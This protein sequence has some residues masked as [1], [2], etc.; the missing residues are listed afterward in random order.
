M[1]CK[2]LFALC[3]AALAGT[4]LAADWPGWRGPDR[5][6]VS[7]E[8]G[9]LKKWPKAGPALLWKFD[10]AG[11]GYS[12]M[13][14]VGDVLYSM[15]GE[16]G[17]EYLFAVDLKTRKKMWSAEVGPIFTEGHG[18]G[19]RGTPTIDGDL[20]FGIGGQGNLICVK[21]GSGE[22]VWLKS[23]KKDFA[24]EMMT[25]WGYTESPLVD[26]DLVIGTP[27]GRQG[28]LVAFKKATGELV[29]QTKDFTDR[30]AYCSAVA[31]DIGG[32]HQVIQ[33]T[34]N[35]VVGVDAKT[36]DVLW[37]QQRAGKTAVIPTPVVKD[38]L[39]YVTSG[40]G[41]GCNLIR[42][43]AANGTFKAEEVYAGKD[44]TNHHGGVVLIGDYLYGYSDGKGWV[45]QELKTGKV[46]W[47][48]KKL[49]K[50]C[51]TAADGQLYLFSED[52]GTVVLIDASPDGWKEKGRFPLPA[53][54]NIPRR[55]GKIW[56]HPTVANGRLYLRDQDLI[57]CFDVKE[58]K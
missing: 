19:P 15:G 55:Q 20:V 33:L 41:V 3:L 40:Y 27:G 37:R 32:T 45:C 31:A 17:K 26:G 30:A 49:G 53:Q 58:A 50:G 39:V 36:G 25:G 44:M 9:L 28:A 38:N 54:T 11:L 43:S 1:K 7:K 51:L 48:E 21:A 16:D 23:F 56:T 5:T 52:E 24:G 6:D 57:L 10:Q 46:A 4:A 22:K 14:V 29:W 12:G 2:S 47:A 42:V 18:D 35:S 34:G 13:A 8:T